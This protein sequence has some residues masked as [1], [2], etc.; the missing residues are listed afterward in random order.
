MYRPRFLPKALSFQSF[1]SFRLSVLRAVLRQAITTCLILLLISN[2]AFAAPGLTYAIADL[3]QEMRFRWHSSVWAAAFNQSFI[4]SFFGL[5]SAVQNGWDGVGAPKRQRPERQ[6]LETK[7]DRERK[8]FDV[9][10]FPGDVTL[11]VGQQAV[12]TAV[13]YDKDGAPIS[14]LDASWE[15]LDEDRNETISISQRATFVSGRPGKYKITATVVGRKAHVKVTVVGTERSAN[16]QSTSE[17][18]V[19]SSDEKPKSDRT[20]MRA[21]A[22]DSS[23]RTAL[24]RGG[25]L[26]GQGQS[27]RA[28]ATG[29]SP[30]AALFLPGEDDYGWNSGNYTTI[31]DPGTE[32]GNM[33]G[34]AVDGGAGSGNFQFAAPLLGLD[35]RGIDLNL[36]LNYNSRLWHKSGTDMY[37]DVDRDWVPGWIL[38]FGKI[39]MAGESYIMVDGDGTR[40][41]YSGKYRGG[42]SSPYSSLQTYEAY[43]TD[44][45][46]INYYAEG[47]KAQFDNSGGHNM[48]RAWAKLPNGTTVEYGAPANYAMYPKQI[49]DANGNYI[50]I[51]YRSYLRYWNNQWLTVEEGPNI[52][53]ITDT[54]GR[55]I[56][57]YYE[58]QGT[59]PNET[60]LLTAVT[61]PGL[62]GSS[63]RVLMRLQYDTKNLSNAGSNY[64]FY[65]VT[66]HVRSATI[67][68]IKA[69]V[70]PATNT[71]YWFGDSD[72]YSNY[73][74]L[75]KVSER[76][77]M[78]CTVGGGACTALASLTQQPSVGSGSMS[79]EVV[80]SNHLN[81]PGYSGVTGSINDTPTYTRMTEDW[82]ARDTAAAPI[83]KFS[84][85]DLGSIR[86]SA[87]TRPDGTYIEQDTDDT[88]SSLYYG[89]L[90][91][92]RTYTDENKTTMLHR[93]TVTWYR[94]GDP[95]AD[96]DNT[97]LTYRSPRPTQTE[98]FDDRNQKTVT[99]FSYGSY[100]NQ[101]A[102][103][104]EYG[105]PGTT[106]LHRI[107]TDYENG[108]LYLGSWV[109][110]GTLW[111]DGGTSPGWS[112]PHLFNLALDVSVYAADNTTRVAHTRYRY[113]EQSLVAR[114]DAGQL[115][116]AP[117]QRGNLTTVKRYANATSLDEAT[118]VVETRNY[119]ACGNAVTLATSCCE[120]TSFQFHVDTRYAWPT[121]ITRGAVSG[122]TN[123]NVTAYG[124]DLNTGLLVNSTDANGRYSETY[125]QT[126][127]LRP[128]WEYAPTNAYAY[129]IYDDT[130][131]VVYDLAYKAGASGADV[132]SRSDKYLD[133]H[134]RVHGE[135][136]YGKDYV[137]D[138]V[139]TKFDDLGRLWQQSRPYRSGTAP[140]YTYEYDKLDRTTK[141]TAPDGSIVER[142]YNE[143]S[144]PSAATQNVPGQTVRAKDPWGRERWARFDEQNRL[145]EVV[146][147]D[148]N[149]SGAVATGG[150][151]TSYVYDTLGNLTL[152][153]Q[154]D[155]TRSFKYDN[156]SRLTAQKLAE[157]DAT[158]NDSG[159]H[160][161]SGQWSDVFNYDNRSNLTWRVEARGVKTLFN[162]SN[163]PLNRLQS[164]QYDTTGIPGSL[165]GNIPAAPNVT[166]AYLTTGDKTRLQTVTMSNGMGNDTFDYDSEGRLS[167][168][169][170]TFPGRESYP[171]VTNYLWD[172]LDR[173]QEL[174]YP[175]QWGITGNPR[176]KVEP[177]Y[178]IANRVDTLKYDAT[179][180]A[181]SFV[182]NASSQVE[183][184]AIG[185]Q[186]TE[187]Y[188][189]DGNTGLL[190]EQE[191]NWLQ[192][193]KI[194]FDL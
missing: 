3:S 116:S 160:V 70:Y 38:G 80:Y 27:L 29:F 51:T 74:M 125:Y 166:Y 122:S 165:I 143:S 88:T 30:N 20:S 150:L 41:P 149:G 138:V 193:L 68:V 69:I 174:T 28:S 112:G 43:T 57:F 94:T 161:G 183:S 131:L 90:T 102:D 120:Q 144:Y 22:S 134:G 11:E 10:I 53:T 95:A 13:A 77:G 33:P 45:S 4:G 151:K 21:P 71:G 155:Q 89:L 65:G 172:S 47:Y 59:A 177:L 9:K 104:T 44:G 169:S 73:G 93:S 181:S 35:G 55:T 23:S 126:L 19:S 145:A 148:P 163:D 76:R 105:Y 108:S 157:R 87:I 26:A 99:E 64:G 103:K 113:D 101:V 63:A 78:T 66:T 60:D 52:E 67:P 107:H 129:H 92:D 191:V 118:A 124:V 96:P 106:R 119:D 139:V 132:S 6:V 179:N 7:Q 176:K 180:Y 184:L 61:A 72:S 194:S 50:T 42:F 168:A 82:A 147:P 135:V 146:E 46:F 130:N 54:V 123:Q 128:E 39:I 37:F 62:N 178:D 5:S 8:V 189:F 115:A 156:L 167:Q 1:Q 140:M 12:F 85:S 56:Q 34:H 98:V 109:N 32:R 153:T 49:I 159:Q 48:V 121:T 164:V 84:V 75:R 79:R 171:L 117:T 137:A 40:H 133:G 188:T 175:A 81:L 152:V 154:G 141:V 91:E 185:S 24:R 190:F 31:D 86:R 14:G 15:G 36:G 18:P 100:F 114:P 186:I 110:R 58:R 173:S 16:I 170:Q 25:K 136:A 158:L 2:N 142:F 83:T 162:Y 182:Y 127:T 97:D 111:F 17:K 187:A 192:V